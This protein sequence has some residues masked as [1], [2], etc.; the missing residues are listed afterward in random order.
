MPAPTDC[1][2]LQVVEIS[3]G[4][5]LDRYRAPWEELLARDPQSDFFDTY[6]WL[7]TWLE[8]FWQD[9]PIA[10][11]FIYR[12]GEL[13]AL[14]PLLSDESGETWCRHTLALPINQ[15]STRADLIGEKTTKDVLEAIWRHLQETRRSVR[16]GLQSV[17]TDSSLLPALEQVAEVHRL[18]IQEWPALVCP[19][20]RIDGDWD[21]YLASLSKHTRSEIRRK[22]RKIE[23]AGAVQLRSVTSPD[24]SRAAMDD[25]L[26][27]EQR[28][29]KEASHS[30]FT[31]VR[32]LADFY[33]TLSLRCALRGWLRSYILYLDHVPV[34]HMV[35]MVYRDRYCALKTS[36]DEQY[37]KLSPGA[38]LAGYA[39]EQ[40]FAERIR[41]F[42]FLGLPSRWKDELANDVREHVGRCLFE[43]GQYRCRTCAYFHNRMKPVIKNHLPDFI[44]RRRD[45]GT[46][47]SVVSARNV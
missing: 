38:V 45:K 14:M 31:A 42:D 33:N 22:R 20:V 43:Q 13:V 3:V 8:F 40:A 16:L 15:F 17:V 6:E 39:L 46:R 18:R 24:D 1:A 5:D 30:S 32:D 10:F 34:A 47:S 41:V 36:F 4:R 7:S 12:D 26:R 19:V 2:R 25:I 27:I 23:R 29:W 44:L 37:S 35:G 11:L 21:G 9:R 28:S